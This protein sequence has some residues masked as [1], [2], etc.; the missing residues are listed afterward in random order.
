MKG[1]PILHDMILLCPFNKT[2]NARAGAVK[3][4]VERGILQDLKHLQLFLL[5]HL[6]LLLHRQFLS[7]TVLHAVAC[8]ALCPGL[9]C[10]QPRSCTCRHRGF[11]LVL[12]LFLD[13]RDFM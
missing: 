10:A 2:G 8:T 12:Y 11:F 1:K 6:P 3:G 4:G 7:E 9:Q 13:W 5:P